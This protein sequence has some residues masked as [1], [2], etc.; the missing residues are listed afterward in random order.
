MLPT[1]FLALVFL[2]AIF[3]AIVFIASRGDRR[4]TPAGIH[5]YPPDIQ[6]KYF[7]TR[8]RVDVGYRPKSVLL[9][10]SLGAALHRHFAGRS[11]G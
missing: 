9:A 8:E 6:E 5:N 3:T 11:S 1:V 4:Y 2:A 10:K 7:R